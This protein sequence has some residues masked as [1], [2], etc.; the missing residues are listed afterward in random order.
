MMASRS[1][2]RSKKNVVTIVE[3][4]NEIEGIFKKTADMTR[5]LHQNEARLIGQAESAIEVMDENL[6]AFKSVALIREDFKNLKENLNRYRSKLSQSIEQSLVLQKTKDL[7]PARMNKII[8]NLRNETLNLEEE[9]QKF[10]QIARNLDVSLS[11]VQLII[12][13]GENINIDE[14]KAQF[15]I[16][17]TALVDDIREVVEFNKM[18]V[19]K[20]DEL[21]SSMRDLYTVFREGG[22]KLQEVDNL[23]VHNRELANSGVERA[24]TQKTVI[25]PA[26]QQN[27]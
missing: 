7:T 18:G 16:A 12:E 15:K 26:P 17:K 23:I 9:M 3:L 5:D 20:D 6:K 11:K 25:S 1:S 22:N 27:V 14:F 2:T 19:E 24:N 4:R 10:N 21:I 8:D 13:K